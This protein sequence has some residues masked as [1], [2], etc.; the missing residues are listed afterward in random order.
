M[1]QNFG[2]HSD[3]RAPEFTKGDL[4]APEGILSGDRAKRSRLQGQVTA[5]PARP[6]L[7]LLRQVRAVAMNPAQILYDS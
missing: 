4:L 1:A 2:A 7:A 3:L 6:T 5:V